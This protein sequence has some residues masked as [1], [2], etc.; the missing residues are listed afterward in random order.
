VGIKPHP[1]VKKHAVGFLA[2]WLEKREF[3][4]FE[5]ERNSLF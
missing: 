4:F 5:V 2:A 1:Q 3:P